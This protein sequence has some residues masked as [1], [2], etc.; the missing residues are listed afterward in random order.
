MGHTGE[1]IAAYTL[2]SLPEDLR[3]EIMG[4]AFAREHEDLKTMPGI[5]YPGIGVN[6]VEKIKRLSVRVLP[7]GIDYLSLKT[8]RTEARQ[9]L[10]A[11][12]PKTVGEAMRISGVSP[13]DISALL[14]YTEE[15]EGKKN[16]R[17]RAE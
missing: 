10:A 13:A 5:F 2:P 9:K 3:M 12:R 6:V 16:D 8:L 15:A 4:E 7:E 11:A 17:P 14:L 1:E